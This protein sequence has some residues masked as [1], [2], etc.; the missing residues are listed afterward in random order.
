MRLRAAVDYY[1]PC[2]DPRL[3]GSLPL[4]VLAGEADDWGDPAKRC[5]L[6]GMELRPDQSFEIHTY[7]GVYHAFDSG[8]RT[9]T[10]ILGHALAYDKAAAEDSF[11]RVRV[12]LD[13]LVRD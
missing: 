3:H 7:P 11:N 10:V 2:I 8:P 6:Y 13:R 1:G 4:L 5:R 12:F 9:K